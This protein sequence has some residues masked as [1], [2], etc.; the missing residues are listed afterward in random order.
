LDKIKTLKLNENTIVVFTSDHG[1]MMGSHGVKPF[2]KQVA[3]DESIKV[4]F[5]ISYPL[6]GENKG[7]MV[8]APINTPDILP[9]LLGLTNILIPESIEGEDLSQLVK[10]P[11]ANADRVALVMNPC[12]FT[13]E[14]V[15]P[16][17]RA[18]R[19]KQYTYARTPKG[20]NKLFDNMKDPHQINNLVGQANFAELQETLDTKLNTELQKIGDEF[21]PREYYVKKWN[22]TLDENKRCINYWDF[23]KGNGMVQTPKLK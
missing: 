23:D 12:P 1:E 14:S 2:A 9:T 22:Y 13:R 3:W 19:T 11:D 16:E 15:Y 5:L 7:V 6:I 20:A 4:P 21:H 8:N 18:I 10:S 17:Y